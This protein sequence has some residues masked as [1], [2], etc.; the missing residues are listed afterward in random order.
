M[1]KKA[2]LIAGAGLTLSMPST[3]FAQADTP[4]IGEVITVGFNFCP[5]NWAEANGALLLIE[6]DT[7]LFALIGTTYG[8]DG[9]T[10]F[11]LPDLR[12][13]AITHFGQGPG[14]TLQ[15]LGQTS[16][17]TSVTLTSANLPAHTHTATVRAQSAAGNSAQP[18]RNSLAQAPAGQNIY[19]TAD[20]NVNMN[21]GDVNVQAAGGGQPITK[22]SPR[23][24]MLNC[25][26]LFGIFPPRP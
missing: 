10:T 21:A 13:R 19:S 15:N 8:G 5:A 20:P 3:A 11:A 23:L 22:T 1:L 24:T 18:T 12:G 26:A 9:Q 4:Y 17:Q 16:G 2:L 6:E 25:V 7:A 14:L